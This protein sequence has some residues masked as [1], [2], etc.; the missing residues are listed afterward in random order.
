VSPASTP[1]ATAGQIATPAQLE[2]ALLTAADLGKDWTETQRRAFSTREP[3]NPSVEDSLA[4][5]PQAAEQ[6]KKLDAL[7]SDAG[8]DVEFEQATA[9]GVAHLVR[10]QAWS[11]NQVQEYFTTLDEAIAICTGSSWDVDGNEVSLEAL[12]A[13]QLGDESTSVAAVA[14]FGEGDDATTWT[15]RLTVARYGATL[16]A[17]SDIIVGGPAP[18]EPEWSTIVQTAGDQFAGPAG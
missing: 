8:A 3:E 1:P 18:A 9:D 2:A 15:T 5:C 11:D 14:T 6:A 13:P 7:A 17:V 12:E 10:Q 4:L 16:M